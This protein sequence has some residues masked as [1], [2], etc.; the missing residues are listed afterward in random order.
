M[1]RLTETFSCP[2]GLKSNAPDGAKPVSSAGGGFLFLHD[3][4]DAASNCST[5]ASMRGCSYGKGQAPMALATN[6][7][8]PA[9]SRSQ[10]TRIV[11]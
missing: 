1:I 11:I 4:A 7:A 6:L 10:V 9:Q 8:G 2:I 3:Q 5:G